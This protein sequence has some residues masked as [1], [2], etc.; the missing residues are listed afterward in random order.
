[1]AN[2]DMDYGKRLF[3]KWKQ[4]VKWSSG[5]E[6]G[7]WET[8]IWRRRIWRE[9]ICHPHSATG[10]AAASAYFKLCT[11]C[12]QIN[13]QTRTP[14]F[15]ETEKEWIIWYLDWCLLFELCLWYVLSY[16]LFQITRLIDRPHSWFVT[17]HISRLDKPARLT[18][19]TDCD[20]L[21]HQMKINK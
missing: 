2:R 19:V 9:T 3:H 7:I 8:M 16:F 18:I 15:I 14:I 5:S 13:E 1:M 12:M 11:P 17:A 21:S 10:W 20:Y 6:P 4:Q